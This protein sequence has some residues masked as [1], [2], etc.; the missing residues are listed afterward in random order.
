MAITMQTNLISKKAIVLMLAF[1]FVWLASL[2]TWAIPL[3]TAEGKTEFLAIGRP[4]AIK[5]A[6]QGP[7]PAG[8]VSISKATGASG[9]ET[10]IIKA[11]VEVDLD[12]MET[13]I[14]MRDRHMKEKYLETSKFKTA[15]LRFV[16]SPVPPSLLKEGGELSTLGT[17]LLHG[18]EKPVTV[19]MKITAEGDQLKCEAKFKLKLSDFSIEIP[20]FSGITVADEVEVTSLTSVSKA[21]S[22]I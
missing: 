21:Q 1:G 13:G 12:A 20:S 17:L 7:G 4:S 16:S 6:G 11:E 3:N 15:V 10:Y 9:G 5:I 19:A 2:K 22:E 18:V 14:G 8:E